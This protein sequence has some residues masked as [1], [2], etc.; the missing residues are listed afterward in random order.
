MV[1][2]LGFGATTGQTSE[3]THRTAASM[4]AVAPGDGEAADNATLEVATGT[5]PGTGFYI[6]IYTIPYVI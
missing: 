5:L 6:R 3:H 2:R 1:S 4:L